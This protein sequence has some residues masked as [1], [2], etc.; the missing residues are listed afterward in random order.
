MLCAYM[1]ISFLLWVEESLPARC[2][3]GLFEGSAVFGDQ[4]EEFIGGGHH[5]VVDILAASFW[6]VGR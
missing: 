5:D 6:A 3:G 1:G 4:G 2:G